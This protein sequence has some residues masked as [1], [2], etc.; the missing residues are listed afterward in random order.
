ML[1][2]SN[3]ANSAVNSGGAMV[4]KE[5][6][7]IFKNFH[8]KSRFEIGHIP[9]TDLSQ[10][11]EGETGE[12]EVSR[13]SG[14]RGMDLTTRNT[15]RC[16]APVD[17][18]QVPLRRASESLYRADIGSKSSRSKSPSGYSDELGATSSHSGNKTPSFYQS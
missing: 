14:P 13:Q 16:Q 3:R 10:F 18:S 5:K 11:M 15:E 17:W 4:K 2:L 6:H 12:L 9:V 7:L 8:G 1:L